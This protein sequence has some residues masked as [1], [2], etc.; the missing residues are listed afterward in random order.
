MAGA[1]VAAARARLA[2]YLRVAAGVNAACALGLVAATEAQRSREGG[3]GATR[4]DAPSW[5][6][7]ELMQAKRGV[8]AVRKRR[9]SWIDGEL[10]SDH[11]GET[12]AVYIYRGALAALRMRG[13][14]DA[15]CEEFCRTHMRT[16][17]HHLRAIEAITDERARTRLLPLWRTAGW[18]LGFVPTV[19]FGAAGLYATVEPVETFVVAH[20]Q[21]QLD[22]LAPSSDNPDVK[23]LAGI[24]AACQADEAHHRDDAGSR[25]RAESGVVLRR[26]WSTVVH[27]GSTLAAEVARH[28]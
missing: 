27:E 7:E 14:N 4:E 1:P 17:Q 9:A 19:L 13:G 16:E 12:G 28:V 23:A 3:G 21:Q 8:L 26:A 25:V 2:Q 11:A 6:P 18:T 15:A 10:A 20:Y 5:P 24:L 22:G